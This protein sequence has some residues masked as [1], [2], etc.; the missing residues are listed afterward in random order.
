MRLL[1]MILL[2]PMLFI[3]INE[4]LFYFVYHDNLPYNYMLIL[5]LL[6]TSLFAYITYKSYDKHYL[7]IAFINIVSGPILYYLF[8]L[9]FGGSTKLQG[10]D[11]LVGFIF[12][13][14]LALTIF[15]LLSGTILGVLIKLIT[16]TR[17][18]V[19]EDR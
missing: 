19:V 2:T 15:S 18:I 16:S 6:I 10:D 7:G 13:T 1:V 9:T 3:M 17:T 8:L 14:Q 11:Y 4:L 5:F 12:F